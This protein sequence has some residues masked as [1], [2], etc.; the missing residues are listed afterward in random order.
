LLLAL[1]FEV[2]FEVRPCFIG[3]RFFVPFSDVAGIN[4]RSGDDDHTDDI[5]QLGFC[6]WGFGGF[7][8]IGVIIDGGEYIHDR[9]GVVVAGGFDF[10]F[11]CG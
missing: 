3:V 4:G 1:L 8:H 5:D 11:C 10:C 2:I 9:F 6:F 7:G